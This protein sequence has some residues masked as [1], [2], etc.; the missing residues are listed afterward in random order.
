MC[1]LK[2]IK[3]NHLSIIKN[4]ISNTGITLKSNRFSY[5][6]LKTD[7]R[8]LIKRTI[9]ERNKICITI[10]IITLDGL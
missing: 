2:I 8:R 5:L 4:V 7:S 3:P 6:Y 1:T 9:Y 10:I